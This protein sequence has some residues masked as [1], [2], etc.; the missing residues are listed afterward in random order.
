MSY[1]KAPLYKAIFTHFNATAFAFGLIVGLFFT[2]YYHQNK[3]NHIAKATVFAICQE[4]RQEM[5]GASEQACGDIQEQLNIE[6]LCDERNSLASNHC[7]T[8]AK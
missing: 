1:E 3:Q 7:W 4:A 6:Y 2:V 5:S 8:E